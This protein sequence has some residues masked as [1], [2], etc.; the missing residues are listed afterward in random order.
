VPVVILDHPAPPADVLPDRDAAR[1]GLILLRRDW[2][3]LWDQLRSVTAIIDYAH[4]AADEDRIPLG[5]EVNRYFDLADRDQR[6]TPDP[7]PA[8]MAQT[9][10]SQVSG[11]TLPREPV[12]ADDI[13]GHD[14]LRQILEDIAAS[15]FPGDE[16][17]RM[18]V[19]ARIDQVAVTHRA[20]LGRLLLRHLDHCASANPS[21]L[22]VQHRVIITGSG[23]LHLAFSVYS[24]LTQYHRQDYQTWL[25]L[26]RQQFLRDVGAEGSDLPWSVGVL[27]SP[28]PDGPRPWDTTMIATNDGPAF[29]EEEFDSLTQVFAQ[30]AGNEPAIT[31]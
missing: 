1:R 16:L 17:T 13:L 25:L 27:L 4:R 19:L 12:D 31:S 18:E 20:E 2:E 9:G 23:R 6:A 14:V 3:F 28:R 8:W 5:T 24:Q 11:P 29:D 7:A 15:S 26:R 21:E 22:A 30:A 10:A